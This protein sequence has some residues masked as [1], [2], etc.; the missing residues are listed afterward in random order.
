[1]RLN[2]NQIKLI[3][4]AAMTLDHL[5]W[6]LFPGYSRQALPLIMHIVGRITCP[7]M[8]YFIAEG[9]HYTKDINR[10]TTRLFL[11]ALISHVPYM[12]M[13]GS[14]V[15]PFAKGE[16]LNQTS[17]IWSLAWGLVMLRIAESRRIGREWLRD[18]LIVLVCLVSLPGDWSCVA[19]LCVLAIGT[20]R[21][22]FKAQMKW[23]L[24]YMAMYSLVYAL[25]IDP[26][27]GL[28]Q[29]SVALS[30]PLLMLCSGER[31]K[32][33]LLMKW[34][35]YIYYPLHLLLLGLIKI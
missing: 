8:C 26:L 13:F 4:I 28:L 3:A 14:S 32:K 12:L 22:N 15:V 23:M 21:G 20:N 24:L 34:S 27:Y 25:T 5:A 7:I 33:S 29:M 30:I 9:Y 2:S 19:S 35:F 17:V 18:V 1:M 10:Y 31:G 11:F 16:I 6:L